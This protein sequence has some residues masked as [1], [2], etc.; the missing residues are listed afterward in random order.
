MIRTGRVALALAVLLVPALTGYALEID[1]VIEPARVMV[2]RAATLQIKI[3][4]ASGAEVERVPE[5]AG[6]SIAYRG[7]GRSFQWINGRTWSGLTLSFSVEPLRS[8]KFTVPP[9]RFRAG[10]ASHQSKAVTLIA[11]QG[12]GE[13]R[14]APQ[15][16]GERSVMKMTALSKKKV[17]AGEPLIARYY[18]LHSGINFTEPSMLRE[19]PETKWFV[20]RF[21]EEQVDD[22][23]ERREGMELVKSHLATFLLVP[24]M[25]GKHTIRGGEVVVSYADDDSF[26]GFPRRA[27]VKLDSVEVEVLPLPETGK[28]AGFDGNVGD[29]TMEVEYEKKPLKVYDETRVRV[30]IKGTGNFVS[31]SP[32]VFEP[33]KDI[34]VI[35]GMNDAQVTLEKNAVTGIREFTYTLIPEREGDIDAGPFTLTFFNPGTGSY[36][37]VSSESVILSVAGGDGAE[38]GMRIEED[39]AGFAPGINYLWIALIVLAVAGVIAGVIFW[40]KS[41]YAAFMESRHKNGKKTE[42]RKIDTLDTTAVD[43]FLRDVILSSGKADPA[44]FL[45]IAERVLGKVC[46]PDVTHRLNEKLS[47]SLGEMKE[48]VYTIRYGGYSIGPDE[49]KEM[50]LRLRGLLKEVREDM[51]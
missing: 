1:T 31:L 47:V 30:I 44:E 42:V 48:R 3:S 8:G 27:Q 51:S 11:V 22:E 38:R 23:I 12:A 46:A 26:F 37:S 14:V 4:G 33:R 7:A 36:R 13:G 49:V 21:I 15:R 25:H 9:I 43:A 28:P 17:Y 29:F 18:L 16:G 35:R 50:S 6:L 34:K 19:L 32:P 45:R 2:G 10:G 20:Q 39:S 5:V 24:S 41:K 40:E